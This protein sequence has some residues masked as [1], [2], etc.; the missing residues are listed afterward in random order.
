LDICLHS[1]HR[2]PDLCPRRTGLQTVSRPV[3]FVGQTVVPCGL[4]LAS[5]RS[6][7]ILDSNPRSGIRPLRSCLRPTNSQISLRSLNALRE[8]SNR[9]T[10]F[11]G[12]VQYYGSKLSKRFF[13]LNGVAARDVVQSFGDHCV[14]F[15]GCTFFPEIARQHI[16]VNRSIQEVVWVRRAAGLQFVKDLT[17]GPLPPRKSEAIAHILKEEQLRAGPLLL[18]ASEVRQ[19]RARP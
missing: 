18:L 5:E 13:A 4:C 15:L 17:P 16:V 2:S 3:L 10:R 1:W 19:L 6:H 7:R 12:G 8:T 14:N 11:V 9:F